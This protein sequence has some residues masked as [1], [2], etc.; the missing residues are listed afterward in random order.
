MIVLSVMYPAGA[1]LDFDYYTS[2]HIPL[3]QRHWGPF[4]V[5]T[6][7]LKGVG[8]ADG[9]APAYQ[10]IALVEFASMDQLH[11]AMASAGTAEITGDVARFTSCQPLTQINEVLEN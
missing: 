7:I 3:L 1:D 10:L 8:S 6:S 5:R 2:E 4:I 9:G 11:A